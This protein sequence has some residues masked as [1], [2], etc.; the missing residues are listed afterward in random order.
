MRI[1]VAVN[2]RFSI[3]PSSI[4]YQIKLRKIMLIDMPSEEAFASVIG[5]IVTI[6][7]ASATIVLSPF[8]WRVLEYLA[9][10]GCETMFV[11]TVLTE[12][13]IEWAYVILGPFG[14]FSVGAVTLNDHHVSK[15]ERLD[16]SSGLISPRRLISKSGCILISGK[17]GAERNDRE[18]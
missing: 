6:E 12:S 15:C 3:I 17:I 10:G 8:F 18:R 7:R 14:S 1:C 4:V 9:E 5:E 11:S 13:G 2:P 16:R